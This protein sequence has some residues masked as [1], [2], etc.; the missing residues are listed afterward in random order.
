MDTHF[1]LDPRRSERP[2]VQLTAIVGHPRSGRR[3]EAE[4]YEI[5]CEGCRVHTEEAFG[6]GDQVLVTIEGLER[7]PARIV[8]MQGGAVG[9]EFHEVLSPG[10]VARYA[11]A[12][13]PHLRIY[14]EAL[15][16]AAIP[17]R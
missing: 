11:D 16:R 9:L 6:L 13:P 4:L 5:S 14:A 17:T 8:W 2:R 1:S 7:W 10:I 3:F 12:F 15:A